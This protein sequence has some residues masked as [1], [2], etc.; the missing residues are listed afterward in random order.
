MNQSP[1]VHLD[2]KKHVKDCDCQFTDV[3][4]EEI[5]VSMTCNDGTLYCS[6]C[7]KNWKIV[8]FDATKEIR[9]FLKTEGYEDSKEGLLMKL[10]DVYFIDMKME[11]EGASK[12]LDTLIDAYTGHIIKKLLEG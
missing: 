6:K 11:P 2:F 7:N 5:G 8:C 3:E 4:I 9:E 1:Y 12:T 10:E